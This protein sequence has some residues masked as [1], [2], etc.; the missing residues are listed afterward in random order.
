MERVI[1]KLD[2]VRPNDTGI[3]LTLKVVSKMTPMMMGSDGRQPHPLELAT[4]LVGDETAMIVFLAMKEQISLMKEGTTVVVRNAEIRMQLG[5]MRLKVDR[6][7][8]IEV[9]VEPANFQVKEDNNLSL[10][11]YELVRVSEKR[12]S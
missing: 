9:Q 6:Q 4:C 3:T 10:I 1:T 5:S 8:S 11:E 2:Q 7:G 12:R